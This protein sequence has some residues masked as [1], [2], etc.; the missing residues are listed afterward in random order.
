MKIDASLPLPENAGPQRVGTTGS[1]PSQNQAEAVGLTPDEAQFSVDGEKVQK[2]TMDVASVPDIRQ[3]RVAALNRAIE[4][5]SY[6]VSDQE[7]AEAM[8]SELSGQT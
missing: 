4:Q 8:S 3:D 6:N 2:L 1:S 7:I 5:G